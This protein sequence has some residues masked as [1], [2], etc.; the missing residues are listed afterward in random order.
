MEKKYPSKAAG[1]SGGILAIQ[2][3]LVFVCIFS[4]LSAESLDPL[5]DGCDE[6]SSEMI[7]P[8]ELAALD[9]S[10]RMQQ[11]ISSDQMQFPAPR[12]E[13]PLPKSSFLA[14]GLSSLIPGLGHVYLG[15]MKTASALVGSVGASL[16]LGFGLSSSSYSKEFKRAYFTTIV[17]FITLAGIYD[18]WV[19]YKNRSLKESVAIHAWYDF[20]L[21]TIGS[22]ASQSLV[23]RC[24]QFSMAIP[25]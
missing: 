11:P 18:G 19:T 10:F 14:V 21:F 22:L 6:I 13:E 17:P 12:L 23:N 1:N 20:V 7:L 8:E 2:T 16:G 15:D 25:F 3:S 24:S 5:E 9:T 4:S